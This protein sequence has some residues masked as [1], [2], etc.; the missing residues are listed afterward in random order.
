M[1]DISDQIGSPEFEHAR[2]SVKSVK[3]MSIANVKGARQ[4]SVQT[5][6]KAHEQGLLLTDNYLSLERT[7]YGVTINPDIEIT[8]Y[9]TLNR[10]NAC[11]AKAP[12]TIAGLETGMFLIKVG[13]RPVEEKGFDHIMDI[14][15]E[16]QRPVQVYFAENPSFN[17]F[18][19]HEVGGAINWKSLQ[20]ERKE[21]RTLREYLRHFLDSLKFQV[22]LSLCIFFDFS[23]IFVSE[24]RWAT[25]TSFALIFF[26]CLELLVR[27]WA[28]TLPVFVS[29][30]MDIFD[31]IIILGSLIVTLIAQDSNIGGALIL[32]RLAKV[33]RVVR[34]IVKGYR[35]L[36]TM[37]AAMRKAARKNR[38]GLY[39]HKYDLDL[40]YITNR[41]IAMTLPSE[42]PRTLYNPLDDVRE[43]L[44]EYHGNHY[45]I[46]NLSTDPEGNYKDEEFRNRVV[47]LPISP[48]HVPT[49]REIFRFCLL[50]QQ[51]ME[52]HPKNIVAVHC[53]RGSSRTGMMISGW[54]LYRYREIL[55]QAG[56]QYYNYMRT[57]WRKTKKIKNVKGVTSPSQQRTVEDFYFFLNMFD[58]D[59]SRIRHKAFVINKVT[60]GPLTHLGRAN[61][62]N[63]TWSYIIHQ[64]AE[65]EEQIDLN[66]TSALEVQDKYTLIGSATVNPRGVEYA[67]IED[68]LLNVVKGSV[69]VT[70]ALN[71]KAWG[72]AW[73][74]TDLWHVEPEV[75]FWITLV[76]E[77]ATTE[78][79]AMNQF[80]LGHALCEILEC[81][82]VWHVD[83]GANNIIFGVE[84][85]DHNDV[86]RFSHIEPYIR[87]FNDHM[88]W[89]M[90]MYHLQNEPE[91]RLIEMRTSPC[92]HPGCIVLKLGAIDNSSGDRPLEPTAKGAGEEFQVIL[93]VTHVDDVKRASQPNLILPHWNSSSG[94]RIQFGEETTSGKRIAGE[95]EDL[96]MKGYLSE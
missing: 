93:E 1:L 16:A 65:S 77:E 18:N 68:P 71:K 62:K 46:F 72:S 85:I 84:P 15:N 48:G 23:L 92:S 12:E 79:I 76:F 17:L 75:G 96:E 90:D 7:E 89:E 69:E 22:F 37:P 43:Y 32:G 19:S 45:K 88:T 94:I 24:E 73:L 34:G 6:D 29:S 61:Q 36:T 40:C 28:Y 52:A 59:L 39:D 8:F 27:M 11:L 83:S 50:V 86:H 5:S 58:H 57:D 47:R 95:E 82:Q 53:D 33:A 10:R 44:E 54:L 51:W 42:K 67:V 70:L 60:L 63:M 30:Y 9:A 35:E 66:I 13:D 3:R 20:K 25:E 14:F 64:R 31:A 38:Q 2:E 21:N 87:T 78:L 41:V 74:N 49:L 81:K 26:Y 91:C 4:N 56:I 55:P 80:H